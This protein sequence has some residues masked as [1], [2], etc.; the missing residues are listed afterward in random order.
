[1]NESPLYTTAIDSLLDYTEHTRLD[2]EHELALEDLELDRRRQ[3]VKQSQAFHDSS[4]TNFKDMNEFEEDNIY[5]KFTKGSPRTKR[6]IFNRWGE[7]VS[8]E[9]VEC[10]SLQ[11]GEPCTASSSARP[12]SLHQAMSLN[13]LREDDVDRRLNLRSRQQQQQQRKTS[14]NDSL[15]VLNSRSSKHTAT[16]F[17]SSLTATSSMNSSCRERRVR[18]S[19]VQIREYNLMI[20]DNPSCRGSCPLQL[21]WEH[22]PESQT[23]DAVL[24]VRHSN[25][26]KPLT[27]AQ[28]RQRV[29]Q[30]RGWSLEEVRL[31]EVQT[32][33][34]VVADFIDIDTKSVLDLDDADDEECAEEIVWWRQS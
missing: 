28:R 27:T 8:T 12:G 7:V 14:F 23:E 29:A 1:M 3:R 11:G 19:T 17:D 2:V 4:S 18:F 34:R 26:P 24:Y 10:P 31:Q 5:E 20:G 30:V 6:R 21:D 15:L 25:I 16:S 9:K 32:M 33:L 22:A 13:A